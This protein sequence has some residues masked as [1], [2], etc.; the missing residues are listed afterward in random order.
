MLIVVIPKSLPLSY[1]S[2][3]KTNKGEKNETN[4]NNK[5]TV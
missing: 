5:R 2:G 3:D 1:E 4:K